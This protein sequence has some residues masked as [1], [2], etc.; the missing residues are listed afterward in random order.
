[1]IA[2]VRFSQFFDVNGSETRDEIMM[3]GLRGLLNEL[4]SG[5]VMAYHFLEGEPVCSATIHEPDSHNNVLKSSRKSL[6]R[7]ASRIPSYT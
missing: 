3:K 2:E 7:R 4:N 5:E 6:S 1:M